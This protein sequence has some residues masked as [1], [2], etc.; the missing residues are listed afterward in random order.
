MIGAPHLLAA[1]ASE[2]AISSTIPTRTHV[3]VIVVVV[4]SLIALIRQ[5][6]RERIANRYTV[7]WVL[8]GVA[9]ATLAA[10]PDLLAWLGRRVGVHYPPALFLA[11][12][13]AFL[14]LVVVRFSAELTRQG[15]RTRQ[16]AEEIALLRDELERRHGDD[17]D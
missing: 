14:F 12:A 5:L 15:E 3:F 9:L 13:V 8:I 7:W 1:V 6:R 16:L 11:L 10:F 4:L 17:D 2:P